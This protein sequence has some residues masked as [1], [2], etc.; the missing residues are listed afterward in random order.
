MTIEQALIALLVLLVLL[1]NFVVPVLRRMLQEQER[2][3]PETRSPTVEVRRRII[4][5]EKATPVP[6]GLRHAPVLSVPTAPSRS[7]RP[8][9]LR[10]ARRA[11]V[12]MTILG[13]CRAND[14]VGGPH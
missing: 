9:T 10:E 13:P 2:E 1:I 8:L 7:F 12:L 14:A 6:Q 4:P 3:R 11:V 5:V